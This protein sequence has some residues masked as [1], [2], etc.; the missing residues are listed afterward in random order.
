MGSKGTLG[1]TYALPRPV[2]RPVKCNSPMPR[3]LPL[4]DGPGPKK[5]LIQIRTDLGDC[6]R[7]KLAETRKNIVFGQGHPYTKLMLIGEAPGEREDETGI[8]FV[9]RAGEL[10]TSLL[11]ELRIERTE[12]YIANCLKCRP[13]MNRQPEEDEVMACRPFLEAQIRSLNPRVIVA[14]GKYAA[15]WLI[16]EIPSITKARGRVWH[17]RYGLVVP[18]YHPAHLLRNPQETWRVREDLKMAQDLVAKNREVPF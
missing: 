15:Q 1:R 11:H 3:Y 9:G 13:P 10:L 18:T 8:A 5:T 14:F 7:C 12:V 17:T 16:G 4:F 2:R 6:R